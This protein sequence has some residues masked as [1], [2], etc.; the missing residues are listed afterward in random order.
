MCADLVVLVIC[1]IYCV[2]ALQGSARNKLYAWDAAKVESILNSSASV[3][4]VFN[5]H[6]HRGGYTVNQGVHYIGME[7][8]LESPEHSNAYAFVDLFSDELVITGFGTVPSR[9]CSLR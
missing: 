5:G 4:A 8:V 3:K 7:G 6:D 2:F 9:K 1:T